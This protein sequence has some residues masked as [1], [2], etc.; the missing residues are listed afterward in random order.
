MDW[1]HIFIW[2]AIAAVFL[3]IGAKNPGLVSKLSGGT[4]AA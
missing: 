3:Y 2:V 1:R 4:V